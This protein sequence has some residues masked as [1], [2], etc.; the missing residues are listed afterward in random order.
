MD[1]YFD[2][3]H[4][5]SHKDE[6]VKALWAAFEKMNTGV[7]A[8]CYL[9]MRTTMFKWSAQAAAGEISLD[10]DAAQNLQ[11]YF[12]LIPVYLEALKKL[13]AEM[14]PEEVAEMDRKLDNRKTTEELMSE[15]A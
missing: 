3:E 1:N 10:N 5:K 12:K 2:S 8:E 9:G 11:N 6:K 14:M 4:F 15:L 13:K 7:A